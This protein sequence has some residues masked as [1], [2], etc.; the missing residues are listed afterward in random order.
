MKKKTKTK[1]I[2]P[3]HIS[4]I[5]TKPSRLIIK[6]GKLITRDGMIPDFSMFA[7]GDFVLCRYEGLRKLY[8][9]YDLLMNW[10]C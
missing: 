7:D 6:D 8:N 4:E 3:Q 2:V 1:V 9:A 10:G 5:F